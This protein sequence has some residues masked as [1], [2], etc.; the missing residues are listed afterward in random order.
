MGL[1]RVNTAYFEVVNT[2]D[3]D[4]SGVGE[5]GNNE[6]VPISD[7]IAG[8]DATRVRVRAL[9]RREF[10][11]VPISDDAKMLGALVDAGVHEADRPL[12]SGPEPI[13]W[14]FQRSLG[15][16]IYRVSTNPLAVTK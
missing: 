2:S 8:A 4:V 11:A 15:A 12:I 5:R 9:T 14:H 16:F 10:D 7:V 3:P 13:P 1:Q 6:W